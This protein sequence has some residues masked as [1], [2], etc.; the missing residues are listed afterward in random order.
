MLHDVATVNTYSTR[1][2]AKK[3]GIHWVTLRRWLASGRI[4]PS[5]ALPYDGRTLWC[6][7][8]EDVQRLREYKQNHYR[9]GRGRKK[10]QSTVTTPTEVIP[11]KQ[12]SE[13]ELERA[14]VL[15]LSSNSIWLECKDCEVRWSP[16]ML[17]GGRLP[18]GYWLCPNGCN[19]PER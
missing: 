16:N 19:K 12:C 7:T 14:G 1:Q 4:R 9:K 5:Q 15:L 13:A 3:A 10:E 6:W 8:E 17:P 2:A 18:K 11:P